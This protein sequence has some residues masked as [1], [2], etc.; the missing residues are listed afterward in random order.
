MPPEMRIG[1]TGSSGFI[2]WHLRC[3]LYQ[4]HD[5]EVIEAN[6]EAFSNDENLERFLANCDGIFHLAG[7]NRGSDKEV[8]DVLYRDKT[9]R[10]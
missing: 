1:I 4:E 7:K 9:D 8:F 10:S 3:L 6:E 2:G 5:I